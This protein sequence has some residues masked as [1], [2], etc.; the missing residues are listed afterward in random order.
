MRLRGVRA[1]GWLDWAR[2]RC[3]QYKC[4]HG[5]KPAAVESAAVGTLAATATL[6]SEP[7]ATTVATPGTPLISGARSVATL[8]T[9]SS[10]G[11]QLSTPGLALSGTTGTVRRPGARGGGA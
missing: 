7:I 3:D 6:T 5:V 11:S 9:P 8:P 1:A 2:E 4:P 10:V